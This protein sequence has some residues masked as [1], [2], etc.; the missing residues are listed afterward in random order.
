[1]A[2][3]RKIAAGTVGLA[4]GHA[5]HVLDAAELLEAAWGTSRR[6]LSPGDCFWEKCNVLCIGTS[7]YMII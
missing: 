6:I 1:M 4:E 2:K 3:E 7:F 5:A